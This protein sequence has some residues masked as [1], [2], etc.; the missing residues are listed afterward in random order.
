MKTTVSTSV[1]EK[2]IEAGRGTSVSNY[3]LPW[4]IQHL[5]LKSWDSVKT[6]RGCDFVFFETSYFIENSS[7]EKDNVSNDENKKFKIHSFR[8]MMPA[9]HF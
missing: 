8:L 4:L 9:T 7:V 1:R 5:L 2:S 6:V 3:S